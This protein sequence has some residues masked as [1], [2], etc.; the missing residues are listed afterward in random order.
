MQ[1]CNYNSSAFLFLSSPEWWLCGGD[2]GQRYLGGRARS[3]LQL[4]LRKKQD[5]QDTAPR[6]LSRPR[7]PKSRR[8]QRRRAPNPSQ[9]APEAAAS[10]VMLNPNVRCSHICSSVPAELSDH[11]A[12]HLQ[13]PAPCGCERS[14]KRG[15]KLEICSFFFF[16]H[17]TL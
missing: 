14:V 16:F 1:G 6:R 12:C 15:S 10:L 3:R 9:R 4:V 13:P 7:Q 5:A 11:P 8:V 17:L 2:G